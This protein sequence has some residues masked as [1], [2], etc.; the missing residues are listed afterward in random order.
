MLTREQ[1]LEVVD[2]LESAQR[3]AKLAAERAREDSAAYMELALGGATAA[4]IG[5]VTSYRG[6]SDL[7]GGLDM[8]VAVAGAAL[9]Y[10]LLSNGSKKSRD[11]ARAVAGGAL[12]VYAYKFGQKRGA[13]YLAKHPHAPAPTEAAKGMIGGRR[14]RMGDDD[15]M[16][17]ASLAAR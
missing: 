14:T 3:R 9:G 11:A 6:R 13:E 12:A 16:R 1:Q 7:I 4:A 10:S 5:A 2:R 17:L 15:L 8:D